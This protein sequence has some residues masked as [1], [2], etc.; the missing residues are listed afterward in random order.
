MTNDASFHVTVAHFNILS[1]VLPYGD[2]MCHLPCI[3]FLYWLI[4]CTIYNIL[5]VMET[6]VFPIILVVE[7]RKLLQFFRY[8]Y[9]NT[10]LIRV[11]SR[12][13]NIT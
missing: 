12:T 9:I 8:N 5:N 2:W 10:E 13:Q 11:F 3:P 6:F 7:K 1:M 4:P